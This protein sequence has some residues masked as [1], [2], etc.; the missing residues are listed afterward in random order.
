M[1]KLLKEKIGESLSSVLPITLIVL[2]LSFTLAPMP[3]GTLMLFILGAAL[4]IVG[5]GFFSMGADMAMMPMG[6][7]MGAQ[8]AKS[9]RVFPV[10]L[11]CFLI[12]VVVT[13]AEPDLQVLARQVPAVPDLV[14]IL[15]VAVGVGVFFGSLHAPDPLENPA[16]HH[17]AGVHMRLS[18]FSPFLFQMNFCQW[19]LTPAASLQVLSQFPL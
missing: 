13:V 1:K 17:A 3:I 15:T 14:I 4:L 5:M 11:L 10:A 9:K 19:P 18:L 16:P 8:L 7:G 2:L 6:D 12:G